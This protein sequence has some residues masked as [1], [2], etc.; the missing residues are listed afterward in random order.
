MSQENVDLV[1]RWYEALARMLSAHSAA[2]GPIEDAPFLDEVFALADEDIEWRWPLTPE[3]FHGRDGMLRAA[4]DWLE[5]VDEWQ[6]ELEDVVDAGERVLASQLVR[7]R[8]KGSGAPTDQH[9]FTVITFRDN[10]ILRL[11][12]Y[13]DRREALHAAGLGK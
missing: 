5:T 7:A 10:R 2:P 8:G 13:L 12:D 1:R 6:I 3:S 4:A 9:V 11:D